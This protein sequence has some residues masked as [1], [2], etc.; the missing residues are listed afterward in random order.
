LLHARSQAAKDAY[1]DRLRGGYS[2]TVAEL[3]QPQDR[4]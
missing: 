3:A 4:P 1:Y 2:V